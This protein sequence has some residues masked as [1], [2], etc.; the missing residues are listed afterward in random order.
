[1]CVCWHCRHASPLPCCVVSLETDEQ[2]LLNASARAVGA[3]ACGVGLAL[4]E[5]AT[6]FAFRRR[7]VG[8]AE[9]AAADG[10]AVNNSS[11]NNN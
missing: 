6:A 5:G 8:P 10:G 3:A 9:G 11:Q 2:K 7:A 1:M 4:S